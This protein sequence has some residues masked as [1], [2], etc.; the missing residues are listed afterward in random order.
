[1]HTLHKTVIWFN[2]LSYVVFV[3][4]VS[5]M[6]TVVKLRN[7]NTKQLT[8]IGPTDKHKFVFKIK[9]KYWLLCIYIRWYF[10]LLLFS[11]LRKYLISCINYQFHHTE[12]KWKYFAGIHWNMFFA[13]YEKYLPVIVSFLRSYDLMQKQNN[14]LVFVISVC[15]IYY[16]NE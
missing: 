2:D 12:T 4:L 10:K 9:N 15:R 7:G 14:K 16:G 1:M 5:I 8:T 13:D 3:C 6:C 11:G